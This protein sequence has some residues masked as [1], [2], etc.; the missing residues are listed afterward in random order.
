MELVEISPRSLPT[1]SA[2]FKRRFYT[3]LIKLHALMLEPVGLH[4][5]TILGSFP[6][7]KLQPS[8]QQ[9]PP[10]KA[11]PSEPL[12]RRRSS[13]AGAG[14]KPGLEQPPR[15][16]RPLGLSSSCLP[17]SVS[18]VSWPA[19]SRSSAPSPWLR[20]TMSSMPGYPRPPLPTP[21]A[22][23]LPP[24]IPAYPSSPSL[25]RG[26]PAYS[27]CSQ[28]ALNVPS[29]PLCTRFSRHSFRWH[30]PFILHP[31]F[32]ERQLALALVW[33]A[34][35]RCCLPNRGRMHPQGM[36]AGEGQWLS[37]ALTKKMGCLAS[38]PLSLCVFELVHNKKLWKI[39]FFRSKID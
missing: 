37:P 32:S 30:E 28:H 24:P 3:L 11:R 20:G 29:M 18:S 19:C 6:F 2:L 31:R 1:V 10:V 23:N 13:L 7:Q 33:P 14:W 35:G 9:A 26:L 5:R 25:P 38:F 12:R 39:M 8:L 21:S 27:A 17:A 36:A 16:P 15:F 22:P 34:R 4:E